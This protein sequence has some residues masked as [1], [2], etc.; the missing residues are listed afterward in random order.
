MLF[1]LKKLSKVYDGRTVL[2]INKLNLEKGIVHGLLGPNG[3][4]KTTLLEILSFIS[5]PTAGELKYNSRIIDSNIGS[6]NSLRREVVL[7]P[8]IPVMFTT[9]VF[10]N[11][12]YGLKIRG[13]PKAERE[14]TVYEMLEM[15]GMKDFAHAKAYKLSGGETQRAAIARALACSPRVIFFDEPTANVDRENQAAI[16]NIIRDI[17]AMKG[18]S[19]I[20]TTHNMFQATKL[21]HN[22][23]FLAEGRLDDGAVDNLYNGNVVERNGEQFCFI[24]ERVM[25]PIRTGRIGKVRIAIDS[26]KMLI[27]PPGENN[28]HGEI[29]GRL[30]QLTGEGSCVRVLA[31]C[32]I[33]LSIILGDDEFRKLQVTIGDEVRICFTEGAVRIV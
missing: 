4:G 18:I 16:E 14:K 27:N 33:P 25:I 6:L 31:D 15:V 1:E 22:I 9:T 29:E 2:D 23:I 12:E 13:I 30:A 3:A 10:K 32:G 19:V 28:G 21:A 20:M 24:H 26:R 5:K 11:V 7:V 8:Q 17:N